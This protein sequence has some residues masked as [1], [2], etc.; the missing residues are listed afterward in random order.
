MNAINNVCDGYESI[1]FFCLLLASSLKSL[2]IWLAVEL[3]D[4]IDLCTPELGCR[5]R[6]T[7]VEFL[8]QRT[9]NL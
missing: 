9:N 6:V 3:V 5:H 4:K 1:I 8:F 2:L 7:S